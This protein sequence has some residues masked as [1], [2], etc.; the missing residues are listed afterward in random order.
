MDMQVT[1]CTQSWSSSEVLFDSRSC[2]QLF[3]NHDLTCTAGPQLPN[4]PSEHIYIY[5]LHL[6]H[7]YKHL[8]DILSA[9]LQVG[10]RPT[11]FGQTTLEAT[12]FSTSTS[13]VLVVL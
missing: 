3:T 11:D 7:L 10:Y 1:M 4:D 8:Q 6:G 9:F 12:A 2:Q 5:T 13:G